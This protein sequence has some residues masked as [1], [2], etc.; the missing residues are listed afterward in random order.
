VFLYL[1]DNEETSNIVIFF[2]AIEI[3]VTIW[4]VL[5]TTKFKLRKD[6]KFPWIELDHKESYKSETEEYD[7]QAFKYLYIA[8][9]PLYIGYLVICVDFNGNF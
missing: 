4:K 8:I 3:I 2:S 5:K 6:K 1:L 7:K 9:A